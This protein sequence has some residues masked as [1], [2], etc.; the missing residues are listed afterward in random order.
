MREDK[1]KINSIIILRGIAALLICIVH[2]S[3]IINFHVNKF[4]DYI[5]TSGQQGVPIFFVISGFILP[6]SLHKKGYVLNNF[7]TFLLRRSV[8]ID[9]PYWCAIA[10]LF[11][12]RDVPLTLLHLKAI[13]LHI[14]YLVPFVKGSAWYS[15]IFWTLSIEFQFYLLLGLFFPILNKINTNLTVVYLLFLSSLFIFLRLDYR[16]IIVTN[17]YDFVIGYITFLGFINKITKKATIAIIILFSIFVMR[18]V[19]YVTGVVPMLTSLFIIFF[20]K[21]KL[22]AC[23]AFT[24]EISYSLYLIHSP[25][26]ALFA[27]EVRGFIVN[28]FLLFPLCLIISISVAYL[29]YRLIEKPSIAISKTLKIGTRSR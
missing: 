1:G 12:M 29:F 8:R 27:R 5:L 11:I 23:L 3:I 28:K 7:F 9:P 25:V 26:I 18:E 24:G 2:A 22:S 10:L 17:F 13:I 15:G 21:N 19:S 6:Y 16:G 14:F 20:E 4:I